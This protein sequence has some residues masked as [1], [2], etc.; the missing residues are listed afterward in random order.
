MSGIVKPAEDTSRYNV[1]RNGSHKYRVVLRNAADYVVPAENEEYI[2]C[3]VLTQKAYRAAGLGPV[4]NMLYRLFALPSVVVKV[5]GV[6]AVSVR[7]LKELAW[8]DFT[9]DS[10][11]GEDIFEVAE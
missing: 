11:G 8:L 1:R 3:E 10:A 6:K 4:T 2:F 5:Y 7:T 9:L